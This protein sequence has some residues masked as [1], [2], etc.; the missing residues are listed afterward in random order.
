MVADIFAK[1]LVPVDFIKFRSPLM[2]YTTFDAMV[3]A[4]PKP[5]AVKASKYP[6]ISS[7]MY[8]GGCYKENLARL[9]PRQII[10]LQQGELIQTLMADVSIAA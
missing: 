5:I 3:D 4:N 6:D 10:P 8:N 7:I 9:W 1:A 2:G